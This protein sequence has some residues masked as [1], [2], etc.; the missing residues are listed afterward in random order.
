MKSKVIALFA[1]IIISSTLVSAYDQECVDEM[2][3]LLGD[4]YTGGINWE[5]ICP[6]LLDSSGSG[7]GEFD[8][9]TYCSTTCE[10]YGEGTCEDECYDECTTSGSSSF[11]YSYSYS[12]ASAGCT[13]DCTDVPE[14]SAA[15]LT[16]AVVAVG[17]GVV[18]L[19]KRN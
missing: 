18:M 4:A 14:F 9:S 8:C 5:F 2:M 16:I 3:D 10:V 7:T 17:L 11:S 1:M 15:T 13:G 6:D 12:Y 19:R